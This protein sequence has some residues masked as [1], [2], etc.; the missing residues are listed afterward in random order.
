MQQ[1][2]QN[3]IDSEIY[4][5]LEFLAANKFIIAFNESITDED[6]EKHLVGEEDLY[7]SSLWSYITD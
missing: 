2:T 6:S 4:D 7:R 1:N 5:A 3:I